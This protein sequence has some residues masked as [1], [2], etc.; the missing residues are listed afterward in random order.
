MN[1]Q[2][3]HKFKTMSSA[4]H[5]TS[6]WKNDFKD[7]W[8]EGPCFLHFNFVRMAKL[9]NLPFSAFFTNFWYSVYFLF[10]TSNFKLRTS[11][12]E[13][14]SLFI[15]ANFIQYRLYWRIFFAKY[16]EN[17]VMNPPFCA[18]FL[19]QKDSLTWGDSY[20]RLEN[21]KVRFFRE[22]KFVKVLKRTSV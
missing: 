9:R 20:L 11:C 14:A 8:L 12:S 7:F 10:E 17:C 21:F 13:L 1:I 6:S 16:S 19:R 5:L 4:F 22:R 15:V 2:L 18:S 3:F